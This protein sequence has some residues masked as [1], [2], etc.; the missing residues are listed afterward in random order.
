MYKLNEQEEDFL[1][2]CWIMLKEKQIKPDL[3]IVKD[4]P[5]IEALREKGLI[6]LAS[7]QLLTAA[8]E[9]EARGCVRR[10][11]LA[12]RLLSD[13]LDCE[14]AVIHQ[15]SCKFEHG[16]HHGLEDSICILL[17]HPKTCPHGKD[18]PAGEC[19]KK[20]D[21]ITKRLVVSLQELIPG[22]GGKI[23]YINTKD[24]ESLKRLVS[25]GILPGNKIKLVSR[26]P[27]Y[28][29]EMGESSFAVDRE[30]AAQIFVL[31]LK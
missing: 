30:L 28:V 18:I 2:S 5:V 17:G 14:D 12:E 22:E 15:A 26:F 19:C 6:D 27:S 11:R 16:L 20:S 3:T 21:K 25:M 31:V 24:S 7:E 13:I 4:L 9:K 23:S 1:E 10:H 29:F 8:G